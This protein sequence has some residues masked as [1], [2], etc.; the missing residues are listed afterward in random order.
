MSTEA[1]SDDS[2]VG[3]ETTSS[4]NPLETDTA[5]GNGGT[6]DNNTA[7]PPSLSAI[8]WEKKMHEISLCRSS[9]EPILPK[10]KGSQF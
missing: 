1:P 9:S 7:K 4:E 3:T 6:V 10:L 5:N 2:P 8:A